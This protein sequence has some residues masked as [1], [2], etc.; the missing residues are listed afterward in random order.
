MASNPKAPGDLLKEACKYLDAEAL[1]T[2]LPQVPTAG[3]KAGDAA[4]LRAVFAG[5][6]LT[7]VH[8]GFVESGPSFSGPEKMNRDEARSRA[9]AC[10][11]ILAPRVDLSLQPPSRHAN[12]IVWAVVDGYIE[13][14][15]DLVAAG[16]P[17]DTPERCVGPGTLEPGGRANA[18]MI[19][20][21]GVTPLTI[22]VRIQAPAAVAALLA[23]GADA[24]GADGDGMTPE[25]WCDKL[26]GRED[27]RAL[28]TAAPAGGAKKKPFTVQASPAPATA[29]KPAHAAAKAAKSPREPRASK[30]K[31]SSKTAAAQ[32][33][34]RASKPKAVTKPAAKPRRDDRRKHT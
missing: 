16:Y 8:K 10:V 11:R 26:G 18:S 22:A 9:G 14:I 5:D 24:H 13:V 30:P 25:K 21:E 3:A 1:A 15:P 31:A 6:P 23:A 2:L 27:M 28:L 19:D 17:L 34:S 32:P 29:A 33:K 7:H 20:E 4:R 12:P